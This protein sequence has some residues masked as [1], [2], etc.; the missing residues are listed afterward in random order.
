MKAGITLNNS[1]VL[2]KKENAQLSNVG[3]KMGLVECLHIS[4]SSPSEW[5]AWD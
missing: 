5:N 4:Y 1:K 3:P 2:V